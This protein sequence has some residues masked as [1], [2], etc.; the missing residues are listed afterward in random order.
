MRKKDP[1]AEAVAYFTLVDIDEARVTLRACQA[2]VT[3][4]GGVPPK[5]A[6]RSPKVGPATQAD[7]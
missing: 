5:R 1:A 4:R 6:Q 3:A 2:V 7:A